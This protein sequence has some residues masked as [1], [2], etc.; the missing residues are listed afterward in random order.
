MERLFDSRTQRALQLESADEFMWLPT[1]GGL[2]RDLAYDLYAPLAF[3]QLRSSTLA[4]REKSILGLIYQSLPLHY[5]L[6]KVY[7]TLNYHPQMQGWRQR[8]YMEPASWWLQ[9][10]SAEQLRDRLGRFFI[11]PD[12][13]QGQWLATR[14]ESEGGIRPNS[15][16]RH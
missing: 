13:D 5:A 3:Y 14:E 9:G 2:I 4:E 1:S 11:V 12:M 15:S 6:A 16:F 8:R 7:P 10:L